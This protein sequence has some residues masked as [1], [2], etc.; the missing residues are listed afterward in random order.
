M[1]HL[2]SQFKRMNAEPTK[3]QIMVSDVKE[4]YSNVWDNITDQIDSEMHYRKLRGSSESPGHVKKSQVGWK[5]KFGEEDNADIFNVLPSDK[6]GK[7]L[8][9]YEKYAHLISVEEQTKLNNKIK[10]VADSVTSA[11][12]IYYLQVNLFHELVEELLEIGRLSVNNID[13]FHQKYPGLHRT[14]ISDLADLEQLGKILRSKKAH[15]AEFQPFRNQNDILDY[16]YRLF[17]DKLDKDSK[18]F[19]DDKESEHAFNLEKYHEF[20]YMT[21]CRD[22]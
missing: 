2:R 1:R 13:K 5:N 6:R 16:S 14:T 21:K 12:T 10:L 17:K 8:W 9:E 3:P 18:P 4:A 19:F 20:T 22:A 11:K 7:Y 15:G